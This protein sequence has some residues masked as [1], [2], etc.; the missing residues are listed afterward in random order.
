MILCPH[1]G[2]LRPL[3][4]HNP[5]QRKP[6]SLFFTVHDSKASLVATTSEICLESKASLFR[7]TAMALASGHIIFP[8]N[9]CTGLPTGLTFSVPVFL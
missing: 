6:G 1:L 3:H 5:G 4:T 9:L 8:L 7:F 2:R